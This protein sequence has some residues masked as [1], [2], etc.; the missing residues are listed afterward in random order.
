M[1][2]AS[3]LPE[4]FEF[5]RFQSIS[6]DPAYAAQVGACAQWL[7]AKFQRMGLTARACPTGGHPVVVARNEPRPDRRTVLIY[8]HY[9]VQP[10]DPLDE[11]TTPPFEPRLENGIVYARGATDNKGQLLAHILGVEAALRE[12][13]GLPVNLIFLVE[14]EEECGSSSLEA[15]LETHR[16]ELQCDLIVISDTGMVAKG[17][18]ALTYGLRGIVSMEVKLSG[19]ATDLHS[20]IYGGVAPNPATLLARLLSKLHDD[21]FRVAVPGFY[22][23]VRPL[24]EWE[25]EEWARLP[26]Q[27]GTFK[28]ATRSRALMGEA[29]YSAVERA[30]ARPTAEVNGIGGGYQGRGDK[31]VI[32]REAFAKLSFRLVPD[33]KPKEVVEKVR[34]YLES[35]CPPEVRMELR[36]GHGGDPLLCDPKSCFSLAARRAMEKTWGTEPTMIRE[37]GSIPILHPLRRILGGEILLLGLALPDCAAHAPNENFPVA[38][39]EAGIRLNQVL[40]EE[41]ARA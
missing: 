37:G 2:S 22:D 6:T 23:D 7:V 15:F 10:V 5:L 27:D 36:I 33:Q 12:K 40:L 31:T 30:W 34:A 24:Q 29:G 3:F 19:A 17:L 13:G 28:E 1:D 16:E 25:R 11:W 14:G 21:Q 35:I 8:G 18:P 20:G 26:L 4:Y 9:D 38:N 41:L 32:P 39:L